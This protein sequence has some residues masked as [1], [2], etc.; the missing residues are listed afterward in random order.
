MYTNRITFFKDPASYADMFII[1]S[2][3][4]ICFQTDPFQPN[5]DLSHLDQSQ[6]DVVKT[7]LPDNINST[8][9]ITLSKW[10]FH[11]ATVGVFVTW[12]QMTLAIGKVPRF[13]K[14]IQMFKR[15]ASGFLNVLFAYMFILVAFLCSFAILF[16]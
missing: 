6:K 2:V 1:L 16:R 10:Q 13:G 12:I 7:W 5:D 11:A 4:L 14:Y 9:T 8:T 3:G 15:V